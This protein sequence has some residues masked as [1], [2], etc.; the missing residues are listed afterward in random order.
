[1]SALPRHLL[2]ESATVDQTGRL[3]VGGCDVIDLA[4]EYGTPLFV[5]DEGHLRA[6]CREG[7]AAFPDGVVYSTKA[8]LCTAMARLAFE[9]G[10]GLDVATGGELHIAL[11]AGVPA[12][13]LVF[14][15][16]NKSVAE[17]RMAL[18]AKVDRIVIDS[19]DEL[20]RVETLVADGVPRPKVLVR[21]NPG[22]EAHTHKYLRTGVHDS[23]FGL[24]IAGGAARGATVAPRHPCR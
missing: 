7:V 4:D 6:R 18:E 1:M 12:D 20:S 8:F 22:I 19:F 21:V 3:A 17:L 14:H 13:R 2:P 24:S 15:G 5:Y 11:A 9:E 16:N 23:K 10:M